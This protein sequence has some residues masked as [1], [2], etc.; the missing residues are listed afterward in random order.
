MN[1]E[2]NRLRTFNEWPADASVS[3]QRIAKAGFYSTKQGLEVECFA[4]RGKIS[5]WNYG[6][7]VIARHRTL[8]PQCPFVLNPAT[9]GNIPCVVSPP[10]IPSSSTFD[11]KNEATRLAS[12]ENWP[13]PDIVTPEALAKAGFYSLRNGDN[14]KCAF[15]KGV[16]RAWE[17]TDIPDFEHKRHFP[18]CPFVVNVINPRI[19]NNENPSSRAPY[20]S[21]YKNVYIINNSVDGSLD[22]LGVQKHNGPKRIDYGTVEARLRSFRTWSPHLIQTADVLAQAGFYY[23]GKVF[24]FI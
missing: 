6:D 3:P 18:S 17:P 19:E 2:E 22:E 10:S 21:E 14:T 9:S 20:E 7:Q 13:I 23:E 11:Y 15:C 5:S 16:V 8:N 1:V 24:I 4:C 12:F